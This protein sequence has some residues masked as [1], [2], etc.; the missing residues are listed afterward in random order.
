MILFEN[1]SWQFG[2][3]FKSEIK[4]SPPN[5]HPILEDHVNNPPKKW[6]KIQLGKIK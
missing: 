4:K 3:V 1:G 5:T 2:G 6:Q